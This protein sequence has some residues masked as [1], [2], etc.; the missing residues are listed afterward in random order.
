MQDTYR[1]HTC[2]ARVVSLGLILSLVFAGVVLLD[3]EVASAGVAVACGDTITADTTLDSDL[4][5]CPNNG[6]IIGADDITLDLNG[7][8]IDGDG[9]PF[10]PCP[11]GEFC[12]VGVGNDGHSGVRVINGSVTEFADGVFVFAAHRNRVVGISSSANAFFGFVLVELTRSAVRNSAGND[13]IPPEGDGLGL[14]GSHRIK[15]VGNTFKR[16]AL[17]I[18]VDDSTNNVIK[19]NLI[20]RTQDGPGMLVQADRNDIRGNVC[21]RNGICILVARGSGNVVARNRVRRDDDGIAV[22]KGRRNLLIRNRIIET[23]KSGIY[24][25]L[26]H[27]PIGGGNNV[28]RQNVVRGSGMDGFRV[29]KKD[30]HSILRQNIA[31]GAGDDG[32]RVQSPT[33]KL[34]ENRAIANGD[35]G[36]RAVEGVIDGGGNRASG[37]GDRRQCVNISCH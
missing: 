33:T 18:H 10:E 12:D 26:A 31:R 17:G 14:F 22:E 20:S 21:R 3:G 6:I 24:L 30:D 27:P 25:G 15:I 7:H 9:E 37:N 32:F 1:P 16:N 23:R 4:T 5:D 34:T 13:N 11:E 29:N 35:L 36:I 8:T 2:W 19:G 28:V